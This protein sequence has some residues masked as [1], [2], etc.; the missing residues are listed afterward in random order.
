[1]IVF[2]RCIVIFESAT[3][4]PENAPSILPK[5]KSFYLL[6]PLELRLH[7]PKKLILGFPALK[8]DKCL[9]VRKLKR[10][11]GGQ[12]SCYETETPISGQSTYSV[13]MKAV[14]YMDLNKLIYATHSL[15]MLLD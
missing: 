1:M 3:I 15:L 11:Q 14:L 5:S 2:S 9:T 12:F 7:F 10:M 8:P 4:N 6:T 13:N